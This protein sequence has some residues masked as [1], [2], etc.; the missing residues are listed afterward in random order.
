MES[1]DSKTLQE[2]SK[3]V[4]G[5]QSDAA[6]TT[7]PSPGQVATSE[8]AE[9]AEAEVAEGKPVDPTGPGDDLRR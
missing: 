5:E 7:A 3:G 4:T 9:H 6:H 2:I 1:G 8:S